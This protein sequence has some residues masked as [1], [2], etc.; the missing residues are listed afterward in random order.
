MTAYGAG[1]AA[2]IGVE[3][4][5]RVFFLFVMQDDDQNGDFCC[6][7]GSVCFFGPEQN[8]HVI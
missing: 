7:L 6:L 3:H 5:F 1:I 8:N 2:F 4:G